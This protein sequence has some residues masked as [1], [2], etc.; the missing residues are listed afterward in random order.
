MH[1]NNREINV[2]IFVASK[3]TEEVLK[4][5]SCLT[6]TESIILKFYKNNIFNLV[7]LNVMMK[8]IFKLQSQ[9]TD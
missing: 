3:T 5:L 2:R 7:N 4:K 1:L 9:N 8:I 6:E